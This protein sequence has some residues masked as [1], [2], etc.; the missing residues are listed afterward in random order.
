MTNVGV[1][2]LKRSLN[3]LFQAVQVSGQATEKCIASV[4]AEVG[5]NG[6]HL[7][8][9]EH[10]KVVSRPVPKRQPTFTRVSFCVIKLFEQPKKQGIKENNGHQETNKAATAAVFITLLSPFSPLHCSLFLK[11]TCSVADVG[12]H[13][14]LEGNIIGIFSSCLSADALLLSIVVFT[15]KPASTV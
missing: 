13:S 6:N 12:I 7:G 14:V 3:A 2:T 8:I 5:Y 4:T 9:H 10:Q 1:G 15:T 11:G